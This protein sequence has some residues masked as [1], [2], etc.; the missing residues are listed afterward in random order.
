MQFIWPSAIHI[1]RGSQPTWGYFLRLAFFT[2]IK[3]CAR[4]TRRYISSLLA[5]STF[6]AEVVVHRYAGILSAYGMGLADVIEEAQEPYSAKYG[7]AALE[8]ASRRSSVLMEE[9]KKQLRLQ[10]NDTTESND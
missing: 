8:E 1:S 4:H 3:I 7:P 2:S 10:V 6:A 9:V 5:L